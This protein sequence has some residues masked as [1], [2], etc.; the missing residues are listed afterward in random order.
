M[1][2]RDL[3]KRK[4]L[5]QAALSKRSGVPR[6]VISEYETGVHDIRQMTLWNAVKLSRVLGCRPEELLNKEDQI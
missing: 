4:E 1:P 6:T 3:R 5:T 2:L